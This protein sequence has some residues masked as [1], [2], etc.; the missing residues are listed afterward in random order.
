M[1]L[2][3]FPGRPPFKSQF[4]LVFF[5]CLLYCIPIIKQ[6][7]IHCNPHRRMMPPVGDKQRIKRVFFIKEL[8]SPLR[9]QAGPFQQGHQLGPDFHGLRR[10]VQLCPHILYV[11]S[12]IGLMHGIHPYPSIC[13][14]FIV[15]LIQK[16]LSFQRSD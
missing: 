14:I 12:R 9:P 16:H 11:M 10:F 2:H 5:H 1:G 7:Q 3:L 15:V 4:F 8:E 13:H 6:H